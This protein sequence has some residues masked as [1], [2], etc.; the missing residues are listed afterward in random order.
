MLILL[1]PSLG[2]GATAQDRLWL[3]PFGSLVT[4]GTDDRPVVES[5]RSCLLLERISP[6]LRLGV[7]RYRIHERGH[8]DQAQEPGR[9]QLFTRYPRHHVRL[10]LGLIGEVVLVSGRSISAQSRPDYRTL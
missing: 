1:I 10:A 9:R 8:D 3:A 6:G 5:R 7:A 4:I 2:F